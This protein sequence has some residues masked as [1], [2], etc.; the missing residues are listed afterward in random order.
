MEE[1]RRN[2]IV[3]SVRSAIARVMVGK[4]EV[5]D[6]TLICLLSKGHVLL[7]DVPGLGKTTLVNALAHALG[8]TYRRIQFTPDVTPSDVTGYSIINM[9][10]GKTETRFGAV[11]GQIILADE[12]NRTSPK[13]QSALLEAMQERQITVDGETYPLPA[14]F[15]VLATQNP[16]EST[17]IYP[18]PEA[19][20][21]RFLM[22]LSLG[23]P[24]QEEEVE[25][26]RRSIL[27]EGKRYAETV[28]SAED[29]LALQ[30]DV[31]SVTCAES[32]MEYI[33]SIVKMTREHKSVALGVSPRGA[34]GL[35]RASMAKALLSGRSY[36]I[37][38]DVQ[39]MV[40]PVLCHRVIPSIQAGL[41][42][43]TSEQILDDILDRVSVPT[44]KQ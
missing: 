39:E 13:T 40:K 25:I 9:N 8:C 2:E 37:P 12:I 34:E 15:M 28:A 6:L 22:K 24:T 29:I 21:D 20:L 17:G 7:E 23:Y 27:P 36:V 32:V 18:L 14:P 16:A 10:T 3:S 41:S 19:Q 30:Q 43:L 26:L 35:L 44:V 4:Q 38:D 31:L 42:D 5:I 1:K 33:V 11:M